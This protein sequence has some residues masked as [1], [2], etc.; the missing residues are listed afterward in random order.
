MFTPVQIYEN[1]EKILSEMRI[2]DRQFMQEAGLK[3][4]ILDSLKNGS[5][6]SGDKLVMIADY[7]NISVD[8]LLG[9]EMPKNFPEQLLRKNTTEEIVKI[10]SS[11]S[12]E[13]LKQ[14]K[15]YIK[16]LAEQ[17]APK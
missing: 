15:S 16:Y 2:S 10:L 17:N 11:M 12:D 13:D 3:R 6:P 7:F 1:I 8:A 9:R 5:M 4:G 14:A